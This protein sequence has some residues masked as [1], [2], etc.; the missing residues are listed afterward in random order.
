M[1][2]SGHRFGWPAVIVTGECG[3][4]DLATQGNDGKVSPS[5]QPEQDQRERRGRRLHVEDPAADS[6]R[7]IGAGHDDAEQKENLDLEGEGR[8]GMEQAPDEARGQKA[9]IE[10][11]IGGQHCR[12][13]RLLDRVA[14][15]L[16]AQRLGPEKHFENEKIDM[17][18]GDHRDQN[19]GDEKHVR[20]PNRQRNSGGR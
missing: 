11:L 19:I 12:F 3:G 13:R 2:V 14:K 7:A 17:Q 9:V 4:T 18:R 6:R 8:I 15:S 5:G 1:I 16:Q 10:A 20:S